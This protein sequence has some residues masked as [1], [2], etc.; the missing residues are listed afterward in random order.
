MTQAYDQIAGLDDNVVNSDEYLRNYMVNNVGTFCH[1]LGTAPMGPEHNRFAVVDQYCC[2]RG[3]DNLWIVDA[4]VFP[5]VPRVV[6]NLTV[7]VL[8]ERVADWL[9]ST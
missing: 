7:I 9:R 3:V 2:V 1:A 6:P 5:A 4:S 8:A